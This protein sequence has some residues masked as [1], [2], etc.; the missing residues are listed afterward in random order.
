M[1]IY[2][3]LIVALGGS[4]GSVARYVGTRTIDNHFN[5]HFPFGTFSVNIIG[6]FII[7]IAY[8]AI[9]RRTGADNWALFLGTGFCG[10]FTTFSAFAFENITL[11]NQRMTGM[12]LIYIVSSVALGL[13]AVAAGMALGKSI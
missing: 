7:G 13:L 2:K 11:L 3:I 6:S 4:L 8:A 9:A 12:S 5:S 10:G 1:N